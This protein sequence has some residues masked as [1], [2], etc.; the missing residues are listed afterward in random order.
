MAAAWVSLADDQ[1]WLDGHFMGRATELA[2]GA[3]DDLGEKGA[4][5]DDIKDRKRQ[6]IEGPAEFR[7]VR[8]DQDK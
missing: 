7:D 1:D 3:I 4:H 6:L 5:R 2:G 8:V